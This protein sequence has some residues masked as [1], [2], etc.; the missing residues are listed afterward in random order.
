M[1]GQ[2][3]VRADGLARPRMDVS[4]QWGVTART[5]SVVGRASYDGGCHR[6][7]YVPGNEIIAHEKHEYRSRDTEPKKQ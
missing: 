1:E 5:S 2:G 6:L 3:A 4:E 7:A